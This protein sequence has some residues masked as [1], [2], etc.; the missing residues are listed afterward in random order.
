MSGRFRR[1]LLAV[2]LAAATGLAAL[3]QGDAPAPPPIP[4]PSP[5]APLVF[6]HVRKCGG[7][8]LR[9]ALWAHAAQAG[10]PAFVPDAPVS[11]AL[12]A[13]LAGDAVERFGRAAWDSSPFR[14]PEPDGPPGRMPARVYAVDGL[15][16]DEMAAVAVFAGHFSRHDLRAVA[17]ARKARGLRPPSCLV[18]VRKPSDAFMAY[19]ATRC[20]FPKPGGGFRSPEN[21]T[22]EELAALLDPRTGAAK[23]LE[24]ATASATDPAAPPPADP[25]LSLPSRAAWFAELGGPT[26]SLL[27]TLTG[28][29]APVPHPWIP[30]RHRL[31]RTAPA[32]PALVRRTLDGCVVLDFSDPASLEQ[33]R[34]RYLPW[35][36]WNA[37]RTVNARAE[38]ERVPLGERAEGMVRAALAEDEA[39]YRYARRRVRVQ[40][41]LDP[42]A[43]REWTSARADGRNR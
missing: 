29:P 38:E 13:V 42:D 35:L 27:R 17:K 40:L 37:S 36:A 4:P 8:G 26:N 30:E 32:D 31:A 18:G 34:A 22:A 14:S 39:L 12:R 11:S 9:T 33:V 21:L 7:T 25:D 10:V 16:E 2:C 6:L 41:G 19:A 1:A 20:P 23:L 15:A 5:A 24:I 3:P 28:A 43:D